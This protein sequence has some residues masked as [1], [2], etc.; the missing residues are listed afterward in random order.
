MERLS[1][2]FGSLQSKSGGVRDGDTAPSEAFFGS[3]G[4]APSP[5][6]FFAFPFFL[7][8]PCIYITLSMSLVTCRAP[9]IGVG[10]N[11]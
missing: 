7:Y 2:A 10:I 8:A 5:R 9:T 6:A 3:V 1:G 11:K 4:A